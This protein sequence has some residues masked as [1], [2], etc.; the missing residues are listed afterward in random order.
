MEEEDGSEAERPSRFS[1]GS[2]SSVAL[3][4]LGTEV[5]DNSSC[6]HSVPARHG[7]ARGRQRGS[8]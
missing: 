4:C 1:T 3:K 8:E 7:T 5:T 2:E 6:C